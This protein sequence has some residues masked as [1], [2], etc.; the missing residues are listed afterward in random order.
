MSPV[1]VAAAV[2]VSTTIFAVGQIEREFRAVVS[3]SKTLSPALLAAVLHTVIDLAV[4]VK[5]EIVP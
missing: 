2:V 1:N 3:A 5:R 4:E